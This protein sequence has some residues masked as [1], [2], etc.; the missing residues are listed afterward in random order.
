[1]NY[2]GISSGFHDAGL[3]IVSNSGDILF[4]GHSERYSK[5][6]HD[7]KLDIGLVNDALSMLMI[8]IFNCTIMKDR[9]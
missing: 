5:H 3:S 6:K 2:I 1:M 9:S 8:Q 4:A 7:N